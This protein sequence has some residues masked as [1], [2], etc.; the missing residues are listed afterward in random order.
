MDIH[1][2]LAPELL[3]RNR[4]REACATIAQG[5]LAVSASPFSY[6]L[7]GAGEEAVASVPAT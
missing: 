2:N 3:D 1:R 7:T 5:L 6:T 4:G